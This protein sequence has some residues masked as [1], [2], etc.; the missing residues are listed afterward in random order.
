MNLIVFASPLHDSN[1]VL[2]CRKS[3]FD[4]L[5]D[6]AFLSDYG[7]PASGNLSIIDSSEDEYPSEDNVFFIA[8]GG[9]E[10]MFREK[11]D[12]IS[13]PVTLLS[14]GYH[15]SLAASFE[16][17]SY[18]EQKGIRHKLINV[19]PESIHEERKD[20]VELPGLPDDSFGDI[21][22]EKTR[23]YLRNSVVGLIGDASPWLIASNV[24]L[25]AVSSEFGTAFINIDIGELIDEYEIIAG[26]TLGESRE[27]DAANM[28]KAIRAL[29]S[30]YEL[31]AL[32]I[33]C[34]DLLDSC[35][36]TS[37]LALSRLNDDGIISGCEGD[38]P[39]LWTMMT[40]YARTG[41]APFMANP[42]ASDRS[43]FSVDFAHCTV[44][45]GMTESYT[46]TTHFESGTGVGVA[47]ILPTGRY[48]IIK[49]GGSR[50]DRMF[51]I[52]GTVTANT[53][54]PQRCR[55]QISFRFDC[56]EDFDRFFSKRL[57]NHIILTD[58]L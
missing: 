34:F 47:G 32:T 18:L 3:L 16:I 54:I 39:A 7:L 5:E 11:L 28:E 9:T 12:R 21:Y 53:R 24:D 49:I 52:S 20:S 41:K 57:G 8:T 27:T 50:L 48:S 6:S 51:R 33:R 55:T 35:R 29:V 25:D 45:L 38:I 37:C 36:T 56:E 43:K 58:K 46:L 30:R 19:N 22:D 42:S 26:D 1:S 2:S 17:A 10:E 44:P 13:A 4:K 23:N 40:V 31:T 14:D 15:N